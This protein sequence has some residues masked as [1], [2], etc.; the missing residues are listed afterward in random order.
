M[1]GYDATYPQTAQTPTAEGLK[2]GQNRILAALRRFPDCGLDTP[3][4][5]YQ[6]DVKSGSGT[7]GNYIGDLRRKALIQQVDGRWYAATITGFGDDNVERIESWYEKLRAGEVRLLDALVVAFPNPLTT[8]QLAHAG[9]IAAGSGTWNNYIGTLRR[10][11][12]VESIGAGSYVA[13]DS[14]FFPIASTVRIARSK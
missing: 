4:L 7:W 10:L 14:H 13:L 3:Q 5:A 6:A 11:G 8:A 2:R 1:S 9:A 12:L